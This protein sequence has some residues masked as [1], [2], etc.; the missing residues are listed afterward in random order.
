M[1]GPGLVRYVQLDSLDGWVV[2]HTYAWYMGSGASHLSP[3][4]SSRALRSLP[5]LSL[6]TI[7]RAANS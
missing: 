6:D 4:M 3:D 2:G 1:F 5:F 7:A